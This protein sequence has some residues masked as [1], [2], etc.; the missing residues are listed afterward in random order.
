M[1]GAVFNFWG[2]VLLLV[3]LPDVLLL[4]LLMIV[5]ARGKGESGGAT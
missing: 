2:P 5:A 1:V 4:L 3:L